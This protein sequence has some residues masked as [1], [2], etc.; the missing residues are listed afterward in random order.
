M[1]ARNESGEGK[2]SGMLRVQN[3]HDSSFSFRYKPIENILEAHTALWVMLP[4]ELEW[5]LKLADKISL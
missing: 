4:N 5:L 3:C 2:V 1:A